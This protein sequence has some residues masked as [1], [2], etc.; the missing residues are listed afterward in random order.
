MSTSVRG[1]CGAHR[2]LLG[3]SGDPQVSPLQGPLSIPSVLISSPWPL[4]LGAPG[5]QSPLQGKRQPLMPGA[6]IWGVA[7]KAR[8]EEGPQ[9]EDPGVL[10]A[11]LIPSREGMI[12]Q[13]SCCT[14]QPCPV[15]MQSPHVSTVTFTAKIVYNIQ[16]II[17]VSLTSRGEF[18]ECRKLIWPQV[19]HLC[20]P[21]PSGLTSV[22]GG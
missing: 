3:G 4:W 8:A 9:E 18:L 5:G 2:G 1:W 20:P 22:A 17:P 11:K 13:G 21:L 14:H 12:R 6:S 19:F 7:S 10:A 15:L 16:E